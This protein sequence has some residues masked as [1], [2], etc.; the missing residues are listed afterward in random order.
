MMAT[1]GA[2]KENLKPNNTS[3][4]RQRSASKKSL[5]NN[6][7]TTMNDSSSVNVS[8]VSKAKLKNIKDKRNNQR[9][10]RLEKVC[11]NYQIKF[12]IDVSR[13]IRDGT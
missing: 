3:R 2:D 1:T 12:T 8:K 7:N 5:S 6:N 4:S 9:L 11:F 13:P 10:A